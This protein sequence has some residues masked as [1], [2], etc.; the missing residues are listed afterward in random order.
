MSQLYN[1]PIT[2]K[3]TQLIVAI[4]TFPASEE[5]TR[6]VT[7]AVDLQEQI[8]KHEQSLKGLTGHQWKDE[9]GIIHG[10]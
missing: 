10:C 6:L 9:E 8:N 4:E 2:Q 7:M 5:Q 3:A 1:N